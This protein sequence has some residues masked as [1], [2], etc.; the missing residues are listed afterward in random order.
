MS[1]IYSFLQKRKMHESQHGY[2]MIFIAYVLSALMMILGSD[3]FYNIRSSAAGISENTQEETQNT[4]NSKLYQDD[5]NEV[6][7]QLTNF[8][9]VNPYGLT[10]TAFIDTGMT[11]SEHAMAGSTSRIPAN[12]LINNLDTTDGTDTVWLLGNA[13]DEDTFDRLIRKMGSLDIVK[14][15]DQKLKEKK[16]KSRNSNASA[17]ATLGTRYSN[18][19]DNEVAMLERIVQAEAGGE[20]MRGKILIANVIMNRVTSKKFPDS[21]K[22]V[23]FQQKDG[24]YQFSP[25]GNKKYWSVRVSNATKEAVRRALKGE[26]YSQGALYFVARARTTAAK[27]RWFD[28]KL[29][30]LFRH[31]GHEF[32]KNK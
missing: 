30:R 29:D 26:D 2:I 24:R 6:T 20:D 13:M 25:V 16:E 10:N 21:I 27:M 11:V 12:P 9:L 23:I 14:E 32:Y 22:G 5:A 7:T 31:G 19:V 18:I 8:S 3:M 17:R 4:S 15:A 28:T 1:I